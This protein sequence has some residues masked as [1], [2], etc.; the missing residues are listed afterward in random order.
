MKH[1]T[2]EGGSLLNI[3]FADSRFGYAAGT[4]GVLLTTVD[5]GETWTAHPGISES[6]L[7]IS[8]SDPEHALI[9]TSASLLF[10][11]DGGLHWSAVSPGQ[12]EEDI[13]EFPY[14]FSLVALDGSHMA[15]MLKQ[16]D[17]QYESQAFL[18]TRDSGKSWSFLNIPNVTLYSFLRAAGRYWA[19]GTEVIH[20]EQPGG[21]Y[22]VP[23]ALYSSDG[24]KWD[25]STGDLS[26]CKLEMCT[27]CNAQ[28]CFSSNGV[29]SRIFSGKTAYSAFPSD[30]KLTTK[31]AATDGVICFVESR[32]ECAGLKNP[33]QAP[34]SVRAPMPTV[35][36]P[37]GPLGAP[38][39]QGVRCLACGLDRIFADKNAQGAYTIKLVL[40]IAKNGTVASVEVEGAPTP[41]VKSGIE[42]QV[43]Q[44]VFEPYLKDG[45]PVDVKLNASV[46]VNVIKSR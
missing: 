11:V 35:V 10:T 36:S 43:R 19:V 32:I 44:W 37:G 2:V 6:I 9:R 28:G 45:V 26:E 1:K 39:P 38:V 42:R 7:Q 34:P 27:A 16:G 25:R 18:F 33:S 30:E 20:K 46:G 13:K 31:W 8:F 3:D 23:V 14:T 5:G 24:E 15:A 21:G 12:N 22:A 41:D 29:V 40:G 17:A 4:G